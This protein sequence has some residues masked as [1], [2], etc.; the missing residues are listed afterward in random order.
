MA[1]RH[2]SLASRPEV[3][4][5]LVSLPATHCRSVRYLVLQLCSFRAL[6]AGLRSPGGPRRSPRPTGER[7]R[8]EGEGA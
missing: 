4:L 3:K 1:L 8:A 2:S 7:L 5:K 6:I